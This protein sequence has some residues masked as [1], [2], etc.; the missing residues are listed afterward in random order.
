[1][2]PHGTPDGRGQAAM[3][4]EPNRN[5]MYD[6]APCGSLAQLVEHRAFNPMVI[7]SNPIRP[8]INLR[9]SFPGTWVTDYSGD[10]GNTF[11]AKGFSPTGSTRLS[12]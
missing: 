8:T 5:L 4:V 3:N 2:T 9:G 11:A 12:L 7:G 6:S 10:M 1:M